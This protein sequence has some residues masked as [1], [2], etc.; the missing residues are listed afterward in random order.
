MKEQE[1]TVKEVLSG[2]DLTGFSI[3]S[4]FFSLL[5]K[6]MS[7]NTCSII[8]LPLKRIMDSQ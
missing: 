8:V 2:N 6:N 4:S 5:R 1:V 3:L 7:L